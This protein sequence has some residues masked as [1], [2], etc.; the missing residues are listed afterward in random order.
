M[1]LPAKFFRVTLIDGERIF[2]EL[3]LA[4][5]DAAIVT[6]AE[7]IDL[8]AGKIAVFLGSVFSTGDFRMYA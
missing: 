4:D 2:G 6:I 7:E 3:Y 8:S 5:V 1:E